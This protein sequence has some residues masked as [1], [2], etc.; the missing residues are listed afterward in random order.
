MKSCSLRY[1]PASSTS[2]DLPAAAALAAITDPPAP[3]PTTHT[4]QLSVAVSPLT[5]ATSM[6]FGACA[7][8]GAAEAG[9]G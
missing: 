3:E 9:P 6:V 5:S 1:W 2:T 8:D 7:A 4:S